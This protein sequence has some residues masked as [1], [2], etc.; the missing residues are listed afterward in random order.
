MRR[1]FDP[2]RLNEIA[3]RP[4][5]RP[6]LRGNG[7]LD[8]S[9]YAAETEHFLFESELGGYLMIRVFDNTYEGHTIYDRT[10]GSAL[11]AA[12]TGREVVDYM[13]LHTNAT[14]LL[15]KI[16]CDNDPSLKLAHLLGFRQQCLREG[17][18]YLNLPLD[19][20]VG[21]CS[22]TAVRGRAFLEHL[23]L[24]QDDYFSRQMGA[25]IGM[26]NAGN[27]EKG[28]DTWNRQ[29]VFALADPINIV[30]LNPLVLEIG[31]KMIGRTKFGWEKY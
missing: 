18:A 1:T 15:G 20:W 14:V 3:N 19:R 26:I 16:P 22:T 25:A 28:V 29:A 4:T 23:G 24:P 9:P 21:A 31:N 17:Y 30:T 11:N 7:A 13:F 27:V 6:L 5:V 8:F 10:P 2:T 12:R